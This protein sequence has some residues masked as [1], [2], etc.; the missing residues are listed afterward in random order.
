[1]HRCGLRRSPNDHLG[2]AQWF[3]ETESHVRDMGKSS[4]LRL[5]YVPG[6]AIDGL[7]HQFILDP[8]P[9]EFVN[10]FPRNIRPPPTI[11]HIFQFTRWTK[12]TI[13]AQ[14]IRNPP[15]S[16]KEIPFSC[17]HSCSGPLPSQEFFFGPLV[18]RERPTTSTITSF[19]ARCGIHHD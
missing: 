11:A 14:T 7:I 13:A 8:N 12:P 9:D 15:T 16:L 18:G 17:W 2:A 10:A 19:A 5:Q 6:R 4:S 1:M 3:S